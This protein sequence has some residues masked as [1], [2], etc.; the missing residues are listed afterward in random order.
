MY[1]IRLMDST[2]PETVSVKKSV[3]GKGIFTNTDL[4]KNDIILKITGPAL[5][6]E[7]TLDLGH[8]ECYCLQVGID[9]YIIPDYPFYLSN[10]S[11]DPNCGIN[12]NMELFA[13]K[14]ISSGEELRWDYST[15]MLERHWVMECKCCA[16]SCR[17]KIKDF[18]LLPVELQDKYLNLGIVMPFI[19]ESLFGPPKIAESERIK[20][21]I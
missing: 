9:K 12:E 3:H 5:N 14:P 6:F 13:L 16:D 7:Q 19:V 10:H 2:N 15:S 21:I 20:R 18:D 1:N 8:D 17:H 11:C 4:S